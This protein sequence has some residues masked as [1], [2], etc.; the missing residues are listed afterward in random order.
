[1]GSVTSRAQNWISRPL[2]AAVRGDAFL[3][4][5]CVC[6]SSSLVGIVGVHRIKTLL[7]SHFALLLAFHD[8]R[9]RPDLFDMAPWGVIHLADRWPD[10]LPTVGAVR[11][12][13]CHGLESTSNV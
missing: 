3:R 6:G 5:L 13:T 11:A 7:F 8:F 10:G 12:N 1:M 4:G 9:L 2:L